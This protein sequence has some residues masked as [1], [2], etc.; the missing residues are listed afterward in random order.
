M[1]IRLPGT[2]K[3]SKSQGRQNVKFTPSKPRKSSKPPSGADSPRS[4]SDISI[5]MAPVSSG[6]VETL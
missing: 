5:V 2:L 6:E 1:R 4:S 3:L